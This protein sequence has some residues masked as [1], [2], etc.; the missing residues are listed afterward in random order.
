VA[1]ARRKDFIYELEGLFDSIK[2][3]SQLTELPI[4]IVD[5]GDNSGA[6]GSADDL[7]ILREMLNQGLKEIIAGPSCYPA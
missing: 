7:T 4:V 6:G 1:W 5:H 2:L 3:V